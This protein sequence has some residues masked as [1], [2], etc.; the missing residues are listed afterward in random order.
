MMGELSHPYFFIGE[1]K[2]SI[3]I[4]NKKFT[5]SVS[6]IVSIIT[7]VVAVVGAYWTVK[8]EQDVQSQKIIGLQKELDAI[9]SDLG[10]IEDV[11]IR[12]AGEQNQTRKMMYKNFTS[13][14]FLRRVT[15]V[16]DSINVD[17]LKLELKRN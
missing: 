17:E 6:T 5:I 4:M 11:I 10:R 16:V 9:D 13:E 14:R 15:P 1:Y 2:M 3:E 7:A 12:M 8:T